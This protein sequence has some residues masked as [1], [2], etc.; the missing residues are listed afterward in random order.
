VRE[1]GR[2]AAASGAA[3]DVESA[4]PTGHRDL[5]DPRGVIEVLLVAVG[6]DIVGHVR[7][8]HV[9]LLHESLV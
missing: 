1:P 5:V 4:G 3:V 9:A 8:E 2:R 7:R 6:C